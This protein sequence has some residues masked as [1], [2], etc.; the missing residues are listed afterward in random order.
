MQQMLGLLGSYFGRAYFL[1][2]HT[3]LER[4]EIVFPMYI[5]EEKAQHVCGKLDRI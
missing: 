4:E 1:S 5:R 2:I 3:S